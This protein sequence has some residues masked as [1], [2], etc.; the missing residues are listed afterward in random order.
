MTTAWPEREVIHPV[1]SLPPFFISYAHA[2]DESNAAAERFYRQLRGDL[3]PLVAPPVGT[4]MGFFDVIG[5]PTGVRWRYELAAALGTCQVL[6]ALL[7]V[8]YLESEWCGKEW[9]AFTMRETRQR[10]DAVIPEFQGPIIPVRWARIPYELPEPIGEEVQI[11]RP[12]NTKAHPDLAERYDRE[13]LFGLLRRGEEDGF[14]D[15][16]LD[17]AMCIQQIYYSQVL[18]PKKFNPD[19]LRNV[20][21]GTRSAF[22]DEDEGEVP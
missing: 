1:P 5:L 20:F 12:N 2:G 7:S 8:R 21:E 15:A 17:L 6:V 3:Q 13:G 14:K 22:D 16:V 4:E 10:P 9:H 19:E 11:F 18:K